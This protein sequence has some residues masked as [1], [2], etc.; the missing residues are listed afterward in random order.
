MRPDYAR[1]AVQSPQCID[2]AMEAIDSPYTHLHRR[3]HGQQAIRLMPSLSFEL[4]GSLDCTLTP[5]R[6][7]RDLSSQRK[8]NVQKDRAAGE[9]Q[10]RDR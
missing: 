8:S 7:L 3:S 9:A 1:H 5:W 6:S 10:Q 2:Q 4:G